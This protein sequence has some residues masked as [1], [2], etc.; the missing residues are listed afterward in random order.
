MIT[1]FVDF[2]QLPDFPHATKPYYFI[3]TNLH[4]CPYHTPLSL[5]IEV[6]RRRPDIIGLLD[7]PPASSAFPLS[8]ASSLTRFPTL[9]APQHQYEAIRVWLYI[10]TFIFYEAAKKGKLAVET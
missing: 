8:R 4:M 10:K 1:G 3:K 5:K 7:K 9:L 6:V 2:T